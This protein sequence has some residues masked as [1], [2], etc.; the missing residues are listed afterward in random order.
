MK[1]KLLITMSIAVTLSSCAK[2][3]DKIKAQYVSPL[4][5][6]GYTCEQISAETQRLSR[7]VSELQVVQKSAYT[8]SNVATGTGLLLFWP[9]LFFIDSNSEQASEYSRLKGEFEALEQAGIQKNCN[10]QI[11]K[12][13]K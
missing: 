12:P 1:K 4:Q 3:P 7:R 10:L 9:A 6:T 11:H 5:Y 2:H 13:N 8:K